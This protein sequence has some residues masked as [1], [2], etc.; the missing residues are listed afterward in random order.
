MVCL[1][2]GASAKRWQSLVSV[3]RPRLRNLS[4]RLQTN[5]HLHSGALWPNGFGVGLRSQIA[6]PS[7]A[8]VIW[9]A[10]ATLS[11]LDGDA[12]AM[13]MLILKGR[14]QLHCFACVGAPLDEAFGHQLGTQPAPTPDPSPP[15]GRPLAGHLGTS[16]A[17]SLVAQPR[18][19]VAVDCPMARQQSDVTLCPS[20]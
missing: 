2:V 4:P 5:A 8:R 7:F 11:D 19:A 15:S 1:R 14:A 20:G 6:G 13:H 17:R 9:L 12:R 16:L 3:V 10:R 18:N